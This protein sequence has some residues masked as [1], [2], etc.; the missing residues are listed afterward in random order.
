MKS[1]SQKSKIPKAKVSEAKKTKMGR[2]RIVVIFLQNILSTCLVRF[3]RGLQ[4]SKTGLK[5][6]L[7]LSKIGLKRG[8]QLSKIGLKRGLQLGKTGLERGREISIVIFNYSKMAFN[9][10]QKALI[11]FYHFISP[12]IEGLSLKALKG[13]LYALRHRTLKAKLNIFTSLLIFIALATGFFAHQMR[14]EIADLMTGSGKAYQASNNLKHISNVH[15]WIGKIKRDMTFL[16]IQSGQ[17]TLNWEDFDFNISDLNNSLL[18]IV[19]ETEALE[20][21][22]ESESLEKIWATIKAQL[23]EVHQ[24][25]TSE[26]GITEDKESLILGI[27]S[28]LENLAKK[29]NVIEEKSFAIS[30]DSFKMA[31]SMNNHTVYKIYGAALGIFLI[32]LLGSIFL[33]GLS[34]QMAAISK[35]ISKTSGQLGQESKNLSHISQLMNSN[36]VAQQESLTESVSAV[37]EITAMNTRTNEI[38]E[39]ANQFAEDCKIEGANGKKQFSNVLVTMEEVEKSNQQIYEEMERNNSEVGHIVQLINQIADKTKVINEIV[40]QTKLLSFNASVEAARAGEHGRGFS[41]VAEEV[42]NL[43]SMSG[44]AADEISTLLSESVSNVE[45]TV[46][47]SKERIN[48]IVQAG[49]QT[50]SS[51]KNV[52]NTCNESMDGIFMGVGQ[53]ADKIIEIK[54]AS[55]E[56]VA[57]V[58]DVQ[59][60]LQQIGQSSNEIVGIGKNVL[61]TSE[62]LRGHT[63]NCAAIISHL[64]RMVYGRPKN[65][66]KMDNENDGEDDNDDHFEEEIYENKAAS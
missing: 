16:E 6:G 20:L 46:Q 25:G 47:S 56:Q 2:L 30:Q 39:L 28:T 52:I 59:N 36:M 18:D 34:N 1:A 55:T 24:M 60:G 33:N 48:R 58:T 11:Q 63:E 5:R 3:K 17:S 40:F 65:N 41:V 14:D 50:I 64:E 22:E 61:S 9:A 7:Q 4:L 51:G 38:C 44:K 10:S 53:L 49:K 31:Y 12:I 26:E 54:N 15:F 29:I 57:G 8:L 37:T 21:K 19:S 66:K 27:A 13:M 42:G 62:D 32:S 45:K 35:K 23:Q 43:A